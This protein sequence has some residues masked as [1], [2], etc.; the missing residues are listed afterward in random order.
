MY[1]H[2]CLYIQIDDEILINNEKLKL[3]KER[4]EF[5]KIENLKNEAI[6]L[7]NLELINKNLNKNDTSLSLSDTMIEL[8]SEKKEFLSQYNVIRTKLNDINK[9]RVMIE[10]LKVQLKNVTKLNEYT[11]MDRLENI[12][13]P[14]VINTIDNIF[15]SIDRNSV[16]YY[17]CESVTSKDVADILANNTGI[18]MGNILEGRL[19][20]IY[21]CIR[22]SMYVYVYIYV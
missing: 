22:I 19:E 11:L 3:I 21:I 8:L 7:K 12:D 5:E 1:T 15:N 20:C 6:K 10:S 13:I 14:N 18:P 16:F 2:L 9:H 4:E 17:L